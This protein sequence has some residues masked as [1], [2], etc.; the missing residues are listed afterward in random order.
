MRSQIAPSDARQVLARVH[1]FDPSCTRRGKR[2]TVAVFSKHQCVQVD[3]IDVAGRNA[4]LTLQSRVSEYRHDHLI[5]LLY[6]ER[7]LFEYYCKMHSIMPIELYPVFK[8]QMRSY[9]KEKRVQSFFRKYRIET[10]LILKALENGSISSRDVV[11][12]GRMKSGWG[13]NTQVS[14]M[15]LTRLWVSGRAMICSRNGAAK[16]YTLPEQILPENLINAA[17]PERGQDLVE[18]TKIIVNASRL[19]TASG[20][21]EQWYHVGKTKEVKEILEGLERNGDV[22]EVKLSGSR[23]KFYAPSGDLKEWETPQGPKEDYVRFLAPLD[24]LLWS[25]NAFASVYGREYFWEVYKKP[26]D[27]KYGYYCL[28]IIFN[29]EYVGLIEPNFRKQDK[30]LEIRNFHFLSSGIQRRRFLSA[31]HNE[32]ER[33]CSYLRAQR[34]EVVKSPLWTRDALTINGIE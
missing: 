34:V 28:P 3:P 14:N 9:S 13:H 27:R 16:S 25:R 17:P 15:I 21:P 6:K 22:F 33:F 5:E 4:D 8:R 31:L 11:D 29:G 1:G 26:G 20:S 19:V 24:P 32:I 18:I 7:R 12:M 10:K 23:E 30:V 2:G